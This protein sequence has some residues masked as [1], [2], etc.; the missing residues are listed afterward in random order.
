MFNDIFS[1]GPVTF[2]MYGLMSAIGILAAY[3]FAEHRAKKENL[4]TDGIIYFVIACLVA[5]YIGSKLLYFCTILPQVLED[6]SIIKDSITGGWVVYGGIIGGMIGGGL[7]CKKKGLPSWKYFDLG[8]TAMA[9]AQGFGRIGCL[10]AGCCYGVETKSALSIVFTNSAYAPNGVHLVPTQIASSLFDFLLFFVMLLYF[11]H[12][13]KNDGEVTGI[14]LIAYSLGRFGIEFLRG[15]L[16]R[17]AVGALS[18]SQF[19]AL[20]TFALGII[21][22]FKRRKA[23]SPME[24]AETARDMEEEQ[25]TEQDLQEGQM[26]LNK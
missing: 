25:T 7:Y 19:I 13:Q 15:D 5:G 9:L 17:G 1:I 23:E 22:F 3:F 4:D 21:I 8:L 20:F 24:S 2:H 16:E 11:E 26:P 10:C 14:Y 6:P 18:T 12:K